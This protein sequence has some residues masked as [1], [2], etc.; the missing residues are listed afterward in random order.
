MNADE[1]RLAAAGVGL[2]AGALLIALGA[3]GLVRL[4]DV[5]CRSHAATKALTLGIALMLSG[6][7]LAGSAPGAVAKILLIVLFQ[8]I[9]IPVA[10]HLLVRAA[11]EHDAPRFRAGRNPPAR[12]RSR[13]PA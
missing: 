1:F 2:V 9:S 5:L 11:H 12:R 13:P 7:A 3:V 10:S 8:V 6:L 4:P